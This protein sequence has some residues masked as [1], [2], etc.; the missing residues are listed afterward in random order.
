MQ[1]NQQKFDHLRTAKGEKHGKNDDAF[2][3]NTSRENGEIS[4]KLTICE[5]Q[6][7]KNMGLR[8]QK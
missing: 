2:T 1:Q 3:S 8:H 5:P 4:S 7:V 6:K